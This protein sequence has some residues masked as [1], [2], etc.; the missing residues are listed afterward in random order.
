[1]SKI[2]KIIITLLTFVSIFC[3]TLAGCSDSKIQFVN[4]EDETIEHDLNSI[5]DIRDYL[6]VY[7][8]KGNVYLATAEVKDKND[9]KVTP[10]LYQF[11][12]EQDTYTITIT[13]KD[14]EEIL[15]SRVL[16]VK[17]V[18]KTPP[19]IILLDMPE[20]GVYNTDILVPVKFDGKG[21]TVKKELRV[22]RYVTNKV[23]GEYVTT[24]DTQNAIVVTDEHFT[25]EGVIFNPKK[26]GNYKISIYAWDSTKSIAEARVIAKN[27][28]IKETADAWGEIEGFDTPDAL[29]ANYHY[30]KNTYDKTNDVHYEEWEYNYLRGI[31]N[32][33]YAKNDAGDYLDAD[34]NIL[35]KRVDES[36]TTNNRIAFYKKADA[37]A[38]DYTV[39]AY[40][41]NL[42][43]FYFYDSLDQIAYTK[44]GC[45]TVKE[46][47]G[48]DYKF[49]YKTASIGEEWYQELPDNGEGDNAITKYGVI[50]AQ[51][52]ENPYSTGEKRFYLSS[53]SKN[54]SFLRLFEGNNSTGWIE[55]PAFDYLSIWVLVKPKD[56]NNSKQSISLYTNASFQKTTVPVGKWFEYKVSMTE[57]RFT[58]Y[59]P[60]D[61]LSSVNSRPKDV[62]SYITLSNDDYNGFDFYFD[63]I[64]Y[65]KGA[66]VVVNSDGLLMGKEFT[67]DIE[68][69]KELTK[70]DFKFYIGKADD[71]K[72]ILQSKVDNSSGYDY[73]RFI[74]N[75]PLLQGT[76]A[77]TPELENGVACRKYFIQAMLNEQGLEKN[78]GEQIYASK[79]ISVNNV[80]V[81]LTDG[82]LGQE[83]TINASLDGFDGVTYEYF[84]KKSA[85]TD[86]TTLATNKFTPNV[87][88]SYDV[89]VVANVGQSQVELVL[90][91]DYFKEIEL[92]VNYSAGYNKYVVNEDIKIDAQLAGSEDMT[93]T[94]VDEF[95]NPVQVTKNTIKVNTTGNYFV[96]ATCT[97]NGVT[98]TKTQEIKVVGPKDVTAEFKVNGQS[99]DI[100]NPLTLN[101]VVSIGVLVDGQLTTQN[102][103]Y[104]V[105]RLD[106]NPAKNYEFTVAGGAF[107]ATLTGVYNI[108]VYYTENNIL[109]SSNMITVQVDA[110]VEYFNDFSDSASVYASYRLGLTAD[111]K[112]DSQYKKVLPTDTL[113]NVANSIA[114]ETYW[115]AEY[116]G[117][118]GVIETKPQDVQNANGEYP[119]TN[120]ALAVALRS[121]TY[122]T[123]SAFNAALNP[124]IYNGSYTADNAPTLA[125]KSP[126]WDYVS[127]WVYLAKADAEQGETTN[128]YG[129]YKMV[130]GANVPYNTWYELKLD[131]FYVSQNYGN[132]GV[133]EPFTSYNGRAFPTFFLATK[134]DDAQYAQNQ[135]VTVYV[136]SMSFNKYDSLEGY[137]DYT[138]ERLDE[139]GLYDQDENVIT[140]T[141][142]K[143][144]VISYTKDLVTDVYSAVNNTLFTVKAKVNGSFVDSSKLQIMKGDESLLSTT[145]ICYKGEDA[146][147][148]TK[149]TDYD[150]YKINVSLL[151]NAE[152]TAL[153][154]KD[155]AV[156]SG[157]AQAMP[158]VRLR[159][160][161]VD[162][163]NQKVYIGYIA[164]CFNSEDVT[165]R[166]TLELGEGEL[167]QEI[168]INA[169][170][171]GYDNLTFE[172]FV[173]QSSQSEW[174]SL[175]NNKFTPSVS[176]S[177]DVKVKTTVNN[178]V[179]EKV[180]TKDYTKEISLSVQYPTGYDKYVT[181]NDI[182]VVAQLEGAQNM[183]VTVVDKDNNP[184]VVSNNVVNFIYTGNYYITATCTYNGV[185]LTKTQEIEVVGDKEVTATLKVNGQEFDANNPIILGDV[186][187]IDTFVNEQLTTDNVTY[188]VVK[189]DS[190]SA[191]N[192]E[193]TTTATG[194]TANYAGTYNIWAYYTEHGVA[195]SSSMIEI[196]VE[197]NDVED[198]RYVNTFS[199]SQ[200][201][202]SSYTKSS[203]TNGKRAD[204]YYEGATWMSSVTDSKGET[205][206]GVISTKPQFDEGSGAYGGARLG[207]YLRSYE[208]QKNADMKSAGVETIVYGTP[209][210]NSTDRMYATYNNEKWD[211]ISIPVYFPKADAQPTDRISVTVLYKTQTIEV[212]YNT[213]F[214]LKLDKPR[215]VCSFANKGAI[216][217][218]FTTNYDDAKPVFCIAT[219]D[220]TSQENINQEV[221]IDSISFERYA[222]YESFEE[223]YFYDTVNQKALSL[224]TLEDV[225]YEGAT[226]SAN[227]ILKAKAGGKVVDTLKMKTKFMTYG[228]TFTATY[229]NANGTQLTRSSG[230]DKSQNDGMYE[231][232][233]TAVT[234]GSGYLVFCFTYTDEETG[235]QYIGYRILT[236]GLV[237]KTT[238]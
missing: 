22:E 145:S 118:Y 62:A 222:G 144:Y 135:N 15:A 98:L 92:T 147:T 43:D 199:D 187:S 1:M 103:S 8:T 86:W 201:V 60:Y 204:T 229:Y 168:T 6:E 36:D 177:Y 151:A 208:Y 106:S 216:L 28:S 227:I 17:G 65:A 156:S 128:V 47:D 140:G 236:F 26:P 221:Y 127:V 16:T 157:G 87:P 105:I 61:I 69:A 194:F 131:K 217:D 170:V 79:V 190:N 25:S 146:T 84:V 132:R 169:S 197:V 125:I 39:L 173:K 210:S 237:K 82:E 58:N 54:N 67:V 180:L 27:Y 32:L 97:F 100:T 108:W 101:D 124:T 49:V 78:N 207:I 11:T 211:Y 238:A 112:A 212:P 90:T 53:I 137:E 224:T 117:K 46:K 231:F 188:K 158:R 18:N 174:T 223:L 52:S 230:Y 209:N 2:R 10:Y 138:V 55:N 70:D 31:G 214:E 37:Q 63:N 196:Q 71:S 153:I 142:L 114:P 12:V 48:S 186:I 171:T 159:V 154:Y 104:K 57:L 20:F 107:T 205:R 161:Y 40:Y 3:L 56:A 213:W 175:S 110:P 134:A 176:T 38:T 81:E 5:F 91:K 73:S 192:V 172:Y 33:V 111:N 218:N 195:N 29:S 74:A 34:G 7:D 50:K 183:T 191:K 165:P 102:L 185:T 89:K 206:Y 96:T 226:A 122:G 59:Y 149:F 126:N 198:A 141:N 45:V 13:I 167:G 232:R 178:I 19:H 51:A 30:Y 95:N 119:S 129:I 76:Y 233:V 77:Y 115:H 64:S 66:D 44:E 116:N 68:N 184:I 219:D 85:D 41:Q 181:N 139:V 42:N 136:D 88:T 35:Y 133:V 228:G 23:N 182:S 121:Y 234:K 80:K 14:D 220:I 120:G 143:P 24:L 203:S 94:V 189:L 150:W 155:P 235:K 164:E 113:E 75:Y 21:V 200:S 160:K 152:G 148:E 179:V 162:E 109:N 93:I 99:F 166:V 72:G 193:I 130:L 123:N 163:V 9:Q 225:E 4:F 202:W 83:I 215:M